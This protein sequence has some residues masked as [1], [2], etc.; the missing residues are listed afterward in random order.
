M[1]AD[2][3]KEQKERDQA[4]ALGDEL[5]HRRARD[6]LVGHSTRSEAQDRTD[7]VESSDIG[8]SKVIRKD[9][10]PFC[11]PSGVPNPQRGPSSW[12]SQWNLE[13]ALPQHLNFVEPKLIFDPQFDG[14]MPSNSVRP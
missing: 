11:R 5:T 7:V 3:T 6:L 10:A 8:K 1:Q 13:R 2:R 4:P 14:R 9:S 12:I